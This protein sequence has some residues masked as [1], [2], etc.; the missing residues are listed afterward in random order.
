MPCSGSNSS[1]GLSHSVAFVLVEMYSL[2]GQLAYTI[3]WQQQQHMSQLTR[4]QAFAWDAHAKGASERRR[5][6]QQA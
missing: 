4:D 1:L 2:A 3:T 6:Q 5:E